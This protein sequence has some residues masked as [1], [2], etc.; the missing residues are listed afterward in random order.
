MGGKRRG[1]KRRR[2]DRR[3]GKSRKRARRSKMKERV[4]DE[5]DAPSEREIEEA[6]EDQVSPY[7]NDQSAIDQEPS[8]GNTLVRS[9]STNDWVQNRVNDKLR[10]GNV[11]QLQLT[12]MESGI[13]RGRSVLDMLESLRDADLMDTDS[14]VD[15]GRDGAW[16]RRERKTREMIVRGRELR[17]V[18]RTWKVGA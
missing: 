7:D 8:T 17:G 2:V 12:S 14:D 16:R 6:E 3:H 4:D 15:D 11:P 9:N 1:M 13:P 5:G 18:G 10:R